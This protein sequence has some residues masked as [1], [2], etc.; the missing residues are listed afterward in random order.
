MGTLLC[1]CVEV[2]AAIQLS[3]EEVSGVGHGMAVVDGGL[4]APRR[5]GMLLGV[6][7]SPFTP[8]V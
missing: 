4:R 5:R 8:I 6:L 1:S 2:R 3:L 7:M